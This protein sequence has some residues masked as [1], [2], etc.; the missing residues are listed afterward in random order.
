MIAVESI[1]QMALEGSIKMCSTVHSKTA[2]IILYREEV[3]RPS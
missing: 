3:S 1:D 2:D